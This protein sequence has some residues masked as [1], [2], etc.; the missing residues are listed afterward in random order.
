M[1]SDQGTGIVN[2]NSEGV[3]SGNLNTND[4]E[5]YKFGPTGIMSVS[6]NSSKLASI[7]R[8]KSSQM[9]RRKKN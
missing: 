5:Y 3:V 7:S 2:I 6:G 9:S 8:L 4:E 1:P